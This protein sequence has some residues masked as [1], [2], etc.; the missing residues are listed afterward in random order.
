MGR[1]S[2][3]GGPGLN[4]DFLLYGATAEN[5]VKRRK[6]DTWR[7]ELKWDQKMTD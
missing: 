2:F 3:Q 6:T 1:G 4:M 7:E 5:N